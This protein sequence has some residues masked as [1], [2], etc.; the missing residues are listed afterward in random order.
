M[1]EKVHR[2]YRN[3]NGKEVEEIVTTKFF[4]DGSREVHEV[5]RDEQGTREK[6]TRYEGNEQ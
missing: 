6:T 4:K 1:H 5:T 3:I 2:H